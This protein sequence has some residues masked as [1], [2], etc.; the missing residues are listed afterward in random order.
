MSDDEPSGAWPFRRPGPPPDVPGDLVVHLVSHTH[1]DREWYAPV[2]WFRR[3]LVVTVDRVLDLLAADP[4]WAFVLDGQGIVV[5]DYL[6]DRPSRVDELVDA[7]RSGRLSIGPWYVQPDSLLPAGEAHVRNLLEGRLVCDSFGGT[8]QVAYTPDSF[9]HPAWFPT[10]L[11]GFG[12]TAFVYWRGHGAERDALPARWRWRA[13]DGAEIL[14]WH[15]EGSYLS[16]ATLEPDAAVAA[17]RLRDLAAV[18]AQRSPEHVLLMNGVDHSMPDAHTAAVGDALAELTGW[19]VRRTTLDDA[20]AAVPMPS[21]TWSGPL[22]GARDANLL[23]GVWSSRLPIKLANR[24]VEAALWTAEHLA[25]AELL[26]RGADAVPDERPGLRR[27]RRR[28]L[29]NQAH[30]SIGGC[31]VDT[32]HDEMAAR[33]SAAVAG[34][35]ALAASVAERLSGLAPAHLAPWA[36]EWDVAVW[37]PLPFARRERVRIPVEGWPAFRVRGTGIERH[38]GH[39]AS[40]DG[41]GFHV[42]GRPARVVDAADPSRDRFSPDQRLVDVETDVELP[43]LGWTTVHLSRGPVEPDV[44]DEGRTL[45]A[46]PSSVEVAADGTVTYSAGERVWPGLF[47]VVE[48]GDR[49]DTYDRDLLDDGDRTRLVDV[50]VVRRTHATGGGEVTVRR[51]FAVPAELSADRSARVDEWASVVVATTLSL[52]PDGRLDVDL[53]VESDARDHL[54]ALRLPLDGEVVHATQF[55]VGRPLPPGA[56]EGWVHGPPDTLCSQG[57]AAAGGLLVLAPGL[58]EIAWSDAGLDVTVLRSV[59]WMSRPDLRTR[60]GRASPAIPV[61]GAQTGRVDARLAL[62]P[63]PVD[64]VARFAALAA[65]ECAPLVVA[66][67]AAP[68]VAA[69][70]P[71]VR[72][73]GAVMTA[74]KPSDDGDAVVIRLWNPTDEHVTA[75]VDTHRAVTVHSCRLDETP[76]GRRE[77]GE[78]TSSGMLVR[79]AAHEVATV[80]MTP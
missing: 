31:S 43:A 53:T 68:L 46:G 65:V 4:G 60:P 26:V 18:L 37:N 67:G 41:D 79:L 28:M 64:H 33:S 40:L 30:D 12:L 76:L 77:G 71:V 58:P 47:A 34:A 70:L 51:T 7:V 3:R 15:L 27:V 14:A 78:S 75:E 48:R 56:T 11:R 36:D 13:G 10:L 25:A 8:S 23:A 69:D 73:T 45:D 63:D 6:A 59:G 9:G 66:A 61:A 50:S 49:G 74:L 22:T 17:A 52:S 32:V 54:V 21:A 2:E 29:E 44:V 19:E 80:R 57:W 62:L 38:P 16:A 55:G 72:V 24:R 39:V 35:T 1:W 5:E 42:D 20:V